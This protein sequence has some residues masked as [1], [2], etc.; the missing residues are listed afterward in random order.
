MTEEI[1]GFGEAQE[2]DPEALVQALAGW[3]RHLAE[4]GWR[5]WDCSESTLRIVDR[6]KRGQTGGEPP[7][8]A[9]R[10]ELGDCRRCK[11]HRSRR[12][13]VFG[14]GNPGADLVFVGEGPG[15]EEDEQGRPFVGRAGQLL[16]KIIQAIGRTREDVYICNVVKCRPPGNRVP[17]PDEVAACAPFLKRQLRAIGPRFLCTLGAVASQYVLGTDA[18]ISALRGKWQTF[19]GIR[20]MPTYHPAYLLRHVDL[21]RQTWNDMKLLMAAMDNSEGGA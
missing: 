3:L 8:D 2:A 6:W 20:V 14:E 15:Q 13:I 19:E 5:G 17:E 4:L 16:S 7:L 10:A 21:K 9:L 12:H 18:P 1:Q 11:L